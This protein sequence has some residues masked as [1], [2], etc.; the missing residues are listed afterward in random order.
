[1]VIDSRSIEEH[2]K[3]HI[4]GSISLLDTEMTKE[5]LSQYA[6]WTDDP[7]IFFCNGTRCMR[8]YNASVKAL[9]WGYTKV[10]WFRGGWKEWMSKGL[11]ISR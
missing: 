10:Y 9:G 1:M 6:A 5:M 7:V 4:E 8:S 11:P 2:A 3:G